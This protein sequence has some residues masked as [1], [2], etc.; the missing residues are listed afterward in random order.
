MYNIRV[1]ILHV[2]KV[3]MFVV[4]KLGKQKKEK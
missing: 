3:Q 4:R 1:R 2:T